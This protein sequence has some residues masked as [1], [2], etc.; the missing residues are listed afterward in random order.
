MM[1]HARLTQR[2][3][4]TE[5]KELVRSIVYVPSA[6]AVPADAFISSFPR[7]LSPESLFRLLNR[8]ARTHTDKASG[9]LRLL[10][11][12]VRLR[13]RTDFRR[14]SRRLRQLLDLMADLSTRKDVGTIVQP[15]VNEIKLALLRGL[16]SSRPHST[17]IPT[18][19]TKEVAAGPPLFSYP[20]AVIAEQ[21]THVDHA[22]F[23]AVPLEEF[24]EKRWEDKTRRSRVRELIE[25]SNRMSEWVAT[26]ILVQGSNAAQ[27]KAAERFLEVA[28]WC[29]TNGN[30]Y[31]V[32]GITGGFALWAVS[33][34][35]RMW[36]IKHSHKILHLHCTAA[37]SEDKNYAAYRA[38][39]SERMHDH[40]PCVPHIAV[41]LRDLTFIEDGNADFIDGA[42]NSKKIGMIGAII[43]QI[44]RLQQLAYA[45]P[46][47]VAADD[48]IAPALLARRLTRLPSRPTE[49]LEQRSKD[50]RPML[51]ATDSETSLTTRTNTER[52]DTPD[53]SSTDEGL[54]LDDFEVSESSSSPRGRSSPR[55]PASPR[56]SAGSVKV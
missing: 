55:R 56:S 24:L 3:T 44:H 49:W 35:T 52:S 7:Y 14:G 11:S 29:L 34:L 23:A 42:P 48:P 28:S 4:P 20:P 16:R 46:K 40:A 38:Q 50:L 15:R 17:S 19:R 30:Y 26:Y 33:R 27:T 43:E 39:L 36:R 10:L 41:F 22:L 47:S 21:L 25:R 18:I 51:S 31:A 54:A 9:C 53:G 12:W 32:S 13:A 37:L 5:V 1:A 2:S 8:E 6:A 45:P